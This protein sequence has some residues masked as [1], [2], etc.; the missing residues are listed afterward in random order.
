MYRTILFLLAAN[1]LLLWPQFSAA[2]CVRSRAVPPSHFVGLQLLH[3]PEAEN[4]NTAV[5]LQ[6]EWVKAGILWNLAET[7]PGQFDWKWPDGNFE[8]IRKHKNIKVLLSINDVPVW[9]KDRKLIPF[10]FR[11]FLDAFSKRYAVDIRHLAALEIFNEPNNPGYGWL[12]LDRENNTLAVSTE[13]SA[14][15]FAEVLKIANEVIRPVAPDILIVSG[16]LFSHEN[17]KD[18]MQAMFSHGISDC[19][20]IFGY[21]PYAN[22]HQFL[23]VQDYLQ[24]YLDRLGAHIPVWY[25]EY[26][27][28]DNGMRKIA[29][30]TVF[31]QSNKLNAQFWF[32]DR[33][34]GIFS[35]TYGLLDYFG[36]PKPDYEM[37]KHMMQKSKTLAPIKN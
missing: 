3:S 12:S 33:D 21:H 35:D 36:N 16:G 27:T 30:T 31:S 6:V 4:W 19:I 37:F 5:D 28:T 10:Y 22:A 17:V 18:Y 20:D 8:Q 15:L 32:L 23:L 2:E 9:I 29:L 7:Q 13:E 26:G 14:A 11:R 1:A 25:T 24:L 34:F